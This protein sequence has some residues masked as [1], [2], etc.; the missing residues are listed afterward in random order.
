MRLRISARTESL[1]LQSR[2]LF[3]QTA[4]AFSAEAARR[5]LRAIQ[6]LAAK[7]PARFGVRKRDKPG[8]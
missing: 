1:P 5:A 8:I 2:E 4:R 6:Q 7:P 3:P